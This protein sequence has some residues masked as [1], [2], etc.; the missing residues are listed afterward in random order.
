MGP[1]AFRILHGGREIELSGGISLGAA[2]EFQR[3]L[4][5]LGDVKIVHLNSP[6]GRGSEA[7][8][9]GQIVGARNL[10]TY[11]ADECLAACTII[12]L[13]SHERLIGPAA[14]LAPP[15]EQTTTSLGCLAF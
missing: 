7:Q 5:T 9:M 2:Q 6:G 11:V 12:F 3:L 4:D 1:A 10:S 8:R 14:R 13:D 15:E